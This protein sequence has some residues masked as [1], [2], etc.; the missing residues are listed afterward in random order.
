LYRD[1]SINTH[2]AAKLFGLFDQVRTEERFW[3]FVTE[4]DDMQ[5]HELELP[6]PVRI[7]RNLA[8]TRR[9]V[10]EESVTNDHLKTAESLISAMSAAANI[11][12]FPK[13]RYL[14]VE[15]V[16]FKGN[17]SRTPRARGTALSSIISRSMESAFGIDTCITFA[18][19]RLDTEAIR[20]LKGTLSDGSGGMS[21]YDLR[22]SIGQNLPS[23]ARLSYGCVTMHGIS[24]Q[25][26]PVVP[27]AET[28]HIKFDDERW[29]EVYDQLAL[30]TRELLRLRAKQLAWLVLERFFDMFVNLRSK[31]DCQAAEREPLQQ[32]IVSR[33][34]EGRFKAIGR[35][36]TVQTEAKGEARRIEILRQAITEELRAAT[37]DGDGSRYW[38]IAQ[39]TPE[40]LVNSFSFSMGEGAVTQS[41][42]CGCGK[43]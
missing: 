16:V 11:T 5:G 26:P 15:P 21:R 13:L 28:I 38:R 19:P 37:D 35:L 18:S 27:H 29:D 1:L 24:L 41:P 4:L 20:L 33:A 34:T 43:W 9:L 31:S 22:D 23:A 10:I 6:F 7:R 12:L 8:H 3:L 17:N 14:C 2:A 40:E 42:C 32:I 36:R 30:S 39:Y 25:L